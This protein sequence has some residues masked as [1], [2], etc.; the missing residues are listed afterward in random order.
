MLNPGKGLNGLNRC[1]SSIV[2]SEWRVGLTF[3]KAGLKNKTNRFCLEALLATYHSPL[4]QTK[5]IYN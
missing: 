4:T 1:W 3:E 5:D 2:S